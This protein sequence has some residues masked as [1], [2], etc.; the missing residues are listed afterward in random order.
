MDII[1]NGGG[2]PPSLNG[3]ATIK[4]SDVIVGRSDHAANKLLADLVCLNVHFNQTRGGSESVEDVC[5]RIVSIMMRGMDVSFPPDE[6][7]QPVPFTT[8]SGSFHSQDCK[9]SLSEDEA[10]GYVMELLEDEA[11]NVMKQSAG[12]GATL[13][14]TFPATVVEDNT[15][16]TCTFNMAPPIQPSAHD[17]LFYSNKVKDP[18]IKDYTGNRRFVQN[19]ELVLSA[20]ASALD[21][22]SCSRVALVNSILE[23]TTET[24]MPSCKP[25]FLIHGGE[26][27]GDWTELSPITT[28]EFTT[29]YVFAKLVEIQ[30]DSLQP[31]ILPS[32]PLLPCG[33]FPLPEILNS[34]IVVP[35]D[36]PNDYDVLFGRGGMT[37][38]HPGNRRFRDIISLHRPDYVCAIKVEKPNVAR[39]IVAAIRGGNPPGRFLKKDSMGLKWYDVGNRHATEK[40]SQ[41]L[42]EKATN[43]KDEKI[44]TEGDVR[45]RLLEQALQEAR[46]TRMRLS[47]EGSNLPETYMD[48]VSG[49]SMPP[50]IQPSYLP[51][52]PSP[53]YVNNVELS[54][55]NPQI[56]AVTAD[57][58]KKIQ[59]QKEELA[60]LASKNDQ[61]DPPMEN[62]G[63]LDSNGS[64]LVTENDILCGRG[65]L[66]NH[67][68]GNKRFRDIVA[69]HRPDYV[70]ASKVHKPAVARL[71]VRA[72]RNSDPP[73][74]FLKKDYKSNKFYDIGDKRATEKASQALREKTQDERS[75]LRP[76]SSE[77]PLAD[78]RVLDGTAGTNETNKTEHEMIDGVDLE[79]GI[80]V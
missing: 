31:A 46:M 8:G 50:L 60:K 68:K 2:S 3:P 7:R 67:H 77:M 9:K 21:D 34:P 48:P 49:I 69:L 66:T 51:I 73:G 26:Q 16:V 43:E 45:K 24:V 65:G 56:D 19:V 32:V 59:I 29:M 70:R 36:K 53:S 4:A 15:P 44:S 23:K 76:D 54:V 55:D 28:A 22:P 13:G 5:K 75:Q 1:R 30:T 74:R 25:R 42:R 80:E 47:K 20:N 37:N 64:I 62:R 27:E 17:I 71:I 6:E 12:G 78:K 41:A 39:R 35:I 10:V 52:A 40:T 57:E 63:I 61:E 38:N 14:N 33:D 79:D 18:Y 58:M 72:I 11:K